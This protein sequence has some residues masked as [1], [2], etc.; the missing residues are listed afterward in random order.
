MTRIIRTLLILTLLTIGS[1]VPSAFADTRNFTV[2]LRQDGDDSAVPAERGL[3]AIDPAPNVTSV[4]PK[5]VAGDSELPT[6]NPPSESK[7]RPPFDYAQLDDEPDKLKKLDKTSPIWCSSDRKRVALG[8][9]ICLREGALEF[10]ACKRNTKDYESIIALDTPPHLIHAALLAIGAKQGTPAKFDPVFVPP[11]GDAIEIEVRWF[12]ERSGV[13]RKIRAQELISENESKET[14]RADWVFTGGLF[15]V[16][17]DG[18]RYYLA[19]VTGE[20]FGVSNF[21][22]SVLDVPFE[23]PSDYSNLFYT[24]NTEKIPPIGTRVLL[25]LT[26]KTDAIKTD[27]SDGR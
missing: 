17:P 2:V 23:S 14:M 13:K 5:A 26:R 3:D 16:D 9:E 25:I 24:P 8:G 1:F 6:S 4:V 11:T 10:F 7:E 12:D 20:V 15:G 21:P 27:N 22:G 18:K 19:N